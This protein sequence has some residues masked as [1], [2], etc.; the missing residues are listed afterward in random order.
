MKTDTKRLAAL[1]AEAETA[2]AS[3]RDPELKRVAFEKILAFLLEQ[4]SG[5]GTKAENTRPSA[6]GRPK[7]AV[8]K[9]DAPAKTRKGPKAYVES[10]IHDGFFEQQRTIAEVKAELAN[11]GHHI[12]LSSLSGPLQTL[13]Q[14]RKLRRQ[15]AT[16]NGEGS[17]TTFAYSHW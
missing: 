13:T 6:A 15:K 16:A 9:A 1:A 5:R 14:E 3:V 4:Q 11:R 17:R 8:V 7:A 10:L 2:V 12:A